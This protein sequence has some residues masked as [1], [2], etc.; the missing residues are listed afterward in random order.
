MYNNI[1]GGVNVGLNAAMPP[2]AI[3]L[4]KKGLE[5]L[6]FEVANEVG[7]NLKHGYNGDLTS[8]DAGYVGGYMVKHMIQDQEKQMSGR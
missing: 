1:T 8:R 2:S 5:D 3:P 4:L 7:V 6:K